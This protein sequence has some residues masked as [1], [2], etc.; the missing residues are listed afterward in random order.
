MTTEPEQPEVEQFFTE[1]RTALHQI[2]ESWTVLADAIEA[3]F[4]APG[5]RDALASAA[6]TDATAHRQS[7]ARLRARAAER[8]GGGL[9]D[10]FFRAYDLARAQTLE[11]RAAELEGAATTFETLIDP[12]GLGLDQNGAAK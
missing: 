8:L 10:A 6:R 11:Q 5:V 4:S 9:G 12:R 1:L 2:R 3:A 7:A